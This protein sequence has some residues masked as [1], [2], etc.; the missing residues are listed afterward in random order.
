MVKG[1]GCT[2][3]L[4]LGSFYAV[5]CSFSHIEG[6]G[7]GCKKVPLFKRGVLGGGGANSFGPAI[8]PFCSLP[9]PVINDQSLMFAFSFVSC[10]SRNNLN[11][12]R[13]AK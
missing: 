11:N 8:F 3:S 5:A 10:V 9:L 2:T 6:G 7:G 4:F 12:K 1:G 13:V